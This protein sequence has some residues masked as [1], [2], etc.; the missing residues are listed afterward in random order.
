MNKIPET[1][2]DTGKRHEFVLL[3]D[4]KEGN[5]NGDPDAANFP[6]I[7]PETGHGI[8]TDVA[9]KRKIRDYLAMTRGTPIFIE[10]RVALN[11][12]ILRA[13]R[14]GGVEP[15]QVELDDEDVIEWFEQ[16]EGDDFAIDGKMLVYSGEATKEAD[17]RDNLLEFLEDGNGDP[18]L[19]TKLR[20]LAKRIAAVAKRQRIST[21]QRDA[22]RDQLCRTY[23]DIRMFGAVLQ[24]GLNAGQVRGPAQITFARSMDPIFP[25]ERA[26]TRQARTTTARM[27]TGSTEFGRKSTVAYG[28][29]RAHGFFNPYLAEK[30]G[31]GSD[32][33]EALWDALRNLFEFDRSAS[34]GEMGV[35]GLYVFSHDSKLGVAP[36]RDLF[37]TIGVDPVQTSADVPPPRK[38]ADYSVVVDESDLP[39][40]ITLTRLVG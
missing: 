6:R 12:K 31:V 27:K 9:L 39:A 34:R 14:E 32:D 8:V 19:P 15:P 28:V 40:G 30:T 24:T 25:V 13:F 4:V 23:Y 37:A 7:D 33:L 3:F 20:T 5:P 18:S 36:A 16:H 1:V 17:I 11:T 10:S 29:Y 38:F 35:C 2:L 26:L 21:K 22:A